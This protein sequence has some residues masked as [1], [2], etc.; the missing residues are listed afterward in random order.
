MSD[1]TEAPKGGAE[2]EDEMARLRENAAKYG[3]AYAA[4]GEAFKSDGLTKLTKLVQWFLLASV[5]G[6]IVLA[7]S[8]KF[9]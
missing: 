3:A 8:S 7:I 6:V 4:F 2:P 9:V 5:V 1:Q